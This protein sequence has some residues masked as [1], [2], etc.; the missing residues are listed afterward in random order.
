MKFNYE[1]ITPYIRRP[2][3][4]VFLK[5][6][7]SFAFYWALI[8]SGADFCI[9]SKDVA[10]LLNI[11]LHSKDKIIFRGI[12]KVDTEGYWNTI[13]LRIGSVSYVTDVIFSEISE[14]GHGILG[15]RGFF[16]HFDI[17]LRHQ[18][19]IIEVMPLE[20]LKN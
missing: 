1:E 2:I 16:D 7:T 3:I 12:N 8:D 6:R 11:K 4:P 9:F 18:K 15:Q 10:N 5:S 14:F 19:K 20:V 17:T 13:T